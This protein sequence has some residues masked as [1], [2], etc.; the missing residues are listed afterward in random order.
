MTDPQRKP[1]NWHELLLAFL[2]DLPDK[3]LSI[4]GHVPHAR[5]NAGIALGDDDVSRGRIYDAV[6]ESDPMAVIV[7]RLPRATAGDHGECAVGPQDGPLRMI[8]TLSGDCVDVQVAKLA[9]GLLRN[10]REQLGSVVQGVTS[11]KHEQLRNRYFAAWRLWPDALTD[12]VD[13]CFAKLP[14]ET[15]TSDHTIWNHLDVTA[16]FTA[17]TVWTSVTPVMLPGYDDRKAV[18]RERLLMECIEHAWIDP[19]AVE[20]NESRATGWPTCS[21]WVPSLPHRAFKWPAYLNQLP[22]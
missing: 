22:A 7:E 16:A 4:Q 10:Q 1:I 14:A 6:T 17:A 18:K 15:R 21:G 11:D 13:P 5:D 2:H 20:H 8:H 9:D 12:K 19:A 3:A